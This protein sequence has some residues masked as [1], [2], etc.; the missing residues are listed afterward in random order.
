M[1]GVTS[2]QSDL[3]GLHESIYCTV[4]GSNCSMK[5]VS[6][7]GVDQGSINLLYTKPISQVTAVI[8]VWCN[9][10]SVSQ[11]DQNSINLLYTKPIS[12]VTAVIYVWCN[13]QSVRPGPW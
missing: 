1:C 8:Y 4:L 3:I 13:V 10:Q 11:S 6:H 5:L 7:T 12:Q 9:V 2:S